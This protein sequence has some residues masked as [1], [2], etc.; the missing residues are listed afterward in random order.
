MFLGAGLLALVSIPAW[1]GLRAAEATAWGAVPLQLWHAHEM[2]FGFA[3]AAIAGFLS[4][5]VPNWTGTPAARGAPLL[6]LAL[7]LTSFAIAPFLLPGYF[8]GQCGQAA[9]VVLLVPV[10]LAPA[11]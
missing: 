8:W 1:I 3:L 10:L 5:A 2:L 9:S 7:A 6:W 4:T 11:H